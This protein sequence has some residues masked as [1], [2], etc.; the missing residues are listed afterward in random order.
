MNRSSN[1]RIFEILS[2]G[3]LWL[4]IFSIP[5]FTQRSADYFNWRILNMDLLRIFFFFIIFLLNTVV[6]VPQ[7][8]LN[9]R[10]AAYIWISIF[11]VIAITILGVLLKMILFPPPEV[12]PPMNLGPGTPPM[13]L[14]PEMP[15]PLGYR[16]ENQPVKDSLFLT[17]SADM[18]ISLLIV[19]SSTAL[20]VISQWIFEENRRKDIEKEQLKTELA[21]LRHQVSPHFFMN[22]LN[23][24]HALIDINTEDAKDT[25]IR[26]STMMRYLLY[27]SAH[28][29]TS[30]K[31]EIE[32]IESYVSLMQLRFSKKVKVFVDV[33]KNVQDIQIP[34]MLFISFLENAFK[35]GVSYQK[36]SFVYFKLEVVNE[37]INCIV[38]NSKHHISEPSDS[39]YSG[40]G[41][42]NVKKSLEL[43]FR[44]DYILEIEDKENEFEISLSV[45]CYE[46]SM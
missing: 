24:I 41:L 23:N 39:A 17:I 6:L 38:K 1:I 14:S 36:D 20:K 11:M 29:K 22:T 45:P 2:I 40:I 30:L 43:L 15:A 33:P 34:P 25:I 35:H 27:D 9:K 8:L 21:L 7:L 42:S 31:K 32:F 18:I 13:E 10:Y 44:K 5:L 16:P 3:V 37:R 26:L 12:M 46:T 19:G 28:G 4:G